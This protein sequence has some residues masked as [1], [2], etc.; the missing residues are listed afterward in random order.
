MPQA[1]RALCDKLNAI[2]FA[3][4]VC[5]WVHSVGA[6]PSDNPECKD[7]I[8][9]FLAIANVCSSRKEVLDMT[10]DND[11]KTPDAIKKHQPQQTFDMKGP[12]GSEI[13]KAEAGKRVSKEQERH[14]GDRASKYASIEKNSIANKENVREGTRGILSKEYAKN[15]EKGIER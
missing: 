6:Q 2:R 12:G 14:S 11:G 10:D 13:R 8:K 3:Y 9:Q 5:I 7:H 15:S 1:L 4:G